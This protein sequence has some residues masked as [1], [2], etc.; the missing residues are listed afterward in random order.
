[1]GQTWKGWKKWEDHP[2]KGK[3]IRSPSN[4]AG[5]ETNEAEDRTG[6]EVK[7]RK[8]PLDE[9]PGWGLWKFFPIVLW[10]D[11]LVQGYPNF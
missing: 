4:E 7:C 3:G 8:E 2:R 10:V 1:M 9:I 11:D 6:G 5:E